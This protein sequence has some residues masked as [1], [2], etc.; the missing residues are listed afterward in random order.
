MPQQSSAKTA[1]GPSQ[2]ERALGQNEA[3][4]EAVEQSADEL[5]LINTVLKQ[6]IPEHVQTGEV[7]EA[8]QKT[9]QLETRIQESAED[10]ANVNEALE[11]EIGERADLEREL[12]ATK[13]ALAKVTRQSSAS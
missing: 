3:V 9:D 6:E 2:L 1:S 4:K 8:L 13:A 10:L 12:E 5:M 7:A 11:Q